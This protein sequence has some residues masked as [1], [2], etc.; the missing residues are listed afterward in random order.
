MVLV[1]L[2][3]LAGGGS[4]VGA[5]FHVAGKGSLRGD[6]LVATRAL[7]TVSDPED[8]EPCP[9]EYGQDC[10]IDIRAVSRRNFKTASGQRMLAF[11]VNAYELYGGLV[12]V[13]N[14]RVPLDTRAG[15]GSDTQIFM[16]L[17][18]LFGDIR[19]ACGRELD[20]GIVSRRYHIKE[21]RDRLTCFVPRR[22]LHPTKRIRFKALSRATRFIVDRA[23]DNGW[24]GA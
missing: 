19:W 21:R 14:F 24:G 16:T 1:A 15:P 3:I 6:Q 5:A 11:S 4:S 2:A 9:E 8:V 13:A 23:P 20:A 7:T 12:F 10:P 17:T 22:A 18:E